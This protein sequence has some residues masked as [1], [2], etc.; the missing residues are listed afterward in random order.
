MTNENK[1]SCGRPIYIGREVCY[2][3][4]KEMF[5]DYKQ[6][7][8]TT[9]VDPKF[10]IDNNGVD[11]EPDFKLGSDVATISAST[12]NEQLIYITDGTLA[13][14]GAIQFPKR[15]V[16][17][18]DA[19]AIDYEKLVTFLLKQIYITENSEGLK[20]VKWMF[21]EYDSKW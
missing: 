19:R 21:K 5:Y 9:I 18:P 10:L 12:N 16:F 13:S 14:Y 15:M 4:Y 1:C 3:C 17:N 11:F 6:D 7:I 2:D 8:K 20:E